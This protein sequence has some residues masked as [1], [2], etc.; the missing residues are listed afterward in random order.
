M[1]LD[2][3]RLWKADG[4]RRHNGNRPGGDKGKYMSMNWA[5]DLKKIIIQIRSIHAGPGLL[6]KWLGERY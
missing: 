4:Q 1:D 2:E 3:K 6:T 5:E